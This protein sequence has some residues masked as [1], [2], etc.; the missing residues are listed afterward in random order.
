MQPFSSVCGNSAEREADEAVGVGGA[1]DLIA[2]LG[3]AVLAAAVVGATL[4]AT[5]AKDGRPSWAMV[6][7]DAVAL[8]FIGRQL[9]LRLVAA[10][11]E[12]VHRLSRSTAWVASLGAAGLTGYLVRDAMSGPALVL[13]PLGVAV[14][15]YLLFLL[16]A[17]ALGL[18]GDDSVLTPALELDQGRALALVVG[19]AGVGYL[20]W[21]LA[22]SGFGLDLN[23]MILAFLSVG[24][25]LRET[26]AAYV[27]AIGEA[28]PGTAGILLQFP[29]YAG[30]L[31]IMKESGLL[32]IVSAALVE[33]GG[34]AA[35]PL[36]AFL[37]AG[38]VNVFVPSG[39]G[40]WAVQGPIVVEAARHLDVPLRTAILAVAYGD[41]WTNMLQP[42]WAL[43]LLGITGLKAKDIVGYTL[44]V[45]LGAGLLFA[46]GLL[47]M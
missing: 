30:I 25:L 23:L 33:A 31:A 41:Q 28:T 42:F 7:V 11:D 13:V 6:V 2:Y 12:A 32:E 21:R 1:L 44:V 45:M 46:A 40:Q 5:W 26:P 38:L 34:Q 10:W 8:F 43:P 39:G 19:A 37:S 20:Q 29:F 17:A 16:P 3:G 24:I 4:A 22:E 36:L 27:E 35:F 14:G 18:R 15:A 47:L 9:I